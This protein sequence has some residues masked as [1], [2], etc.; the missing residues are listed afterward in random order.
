ML[1]GNI[2]RRTLIQL[3][4]HPP[5]PWVTSAIHRLSF[6]NKLFQGCRR[7]LEANFI[8]LCN[9]PSQ[10]VGAALCYSAWLCHKEL[11]FGV[12]DLLSSCRQLLGCPSAFLWPDSTHLNPFHKVWIPFWRCVL[13]AS[14]H[15]GSISESN[16]KEAKSQ[17]HL[18]VHIHGEIL[19]YKHFPGKKKF[20][21]GF[22]SRLY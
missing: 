17:Q 14:D 3:C 2:S 18:G 15:L 9:L 12:L 5:E 11:K 20:K 22:I 21:G 13:P 19:I 7:C 4:F 6:P 8:L 10:S 16:F 1:F